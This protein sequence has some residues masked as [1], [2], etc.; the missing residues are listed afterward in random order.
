MLNALLGS[1]IFKDASSPEQ[2]SF[3]NQLLPK[4]DLEDILTNE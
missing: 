1:N 2:V 4:S 3:N